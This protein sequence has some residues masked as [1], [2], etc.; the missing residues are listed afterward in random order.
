MT[1]PGLTR[2]QRDRIGGFLEK[3]AVGTCLAGIAITDTAIMTRVQ[4]IIWSAVMLGAAAW[5]DGP[6]QRRR[7]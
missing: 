6:L 5:L 4:A 7:R 2:H 1:H 3:V